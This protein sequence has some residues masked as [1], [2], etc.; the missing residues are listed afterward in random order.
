[1]DDIITTI[2]QFIYKFKLDIY[3]AYH[4]I[5]INEEDILKTAVVTQDYHIEFT[6]VM[7]GLVG[8][9][10]IMSKVIKSTYGCLYNDG[11]R[12]YFDD[13]TGGKNSIE[14]F[15]AILRKVFEQTRKKNL[16]L[17]K[18]KCIFIANEYQISNSNSISISKYL[19]LEN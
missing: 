8:G 7:F 15:I 18:E 16:K 3:H 9:L 4:N 1:M 2:S 10:S 6:R 19:Y 12:A 14:E 17:N 5:C 11:V 13:I